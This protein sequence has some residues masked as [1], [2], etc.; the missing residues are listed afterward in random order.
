MRSRMMRSRLDPMKSLARQPRRHWDDVLAY[1]GHRCAN[2]ILEGLNSIIQN[3]KIHARGFRNM[4]C[5]NAMIC[6]RQIRS[7]NRHY[8][9]DFTHTKQRKATGQT[10]P[11]F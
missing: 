9:T 8:L 3:V 7:T 10:E 2:V 11:N 1:F 5:F 4:N 6:L